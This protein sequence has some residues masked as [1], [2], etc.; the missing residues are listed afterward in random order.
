[1]HQKNPLTQ[2]TLE[3]RPSAISRRAFIAGLL[4][5]PVAACSNIG[6]DQ[7][8]TRALPS[9]AQNI[10]RAVLFYLAGLPDYPISRDIVNNLPY[11][12]MAAKIGKGPHSLLVLWRRE[13]D[14][15]H[16]LSAD[17]AVLVTRGGRVVKTAGL[18]ENIRD[19]IFI[20]ADPVAAGLH[21]GASGITSK[22]TLDIEPGQY[23]L[24]VDS[25]FEVRGP[26]RITITEIDFDTILVVER[27]VAQTVN[28]SFN[29]LY[30]VDPADGFVW[31]SRQHIAR[32]FPPAVIE[33]LKPAA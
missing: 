20:G 14:D 2:S 27:N 28:W 11:A 31:K 32:G 12:S 23:T 6:F 21:H 33:M 9:F 19:T 8:V 16:W 29:N 18:S 15:L 17:N 4:S 26:R 10:T 1:M 24:P 13:R 30:W 25:T 3:I 22:R 5:L 7:S